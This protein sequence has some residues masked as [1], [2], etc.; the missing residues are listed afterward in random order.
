[1]P[2]MKLPLTNVN[3]SNKNRKRKLNS[4]SPSNNTPSQSRR[5][6]KCLGCGAAKRWD[7]L[8]D[9]YRKYVAF[10]PLGKPLPP[11]LDTMTP[12]Q[13]V[14][15]M[16]FRDQ[17]FA[18]DRMPQY[19]DHTEAGQDASEEDNTVTDEST[20]NSV[21]GMETNSAMIPPSL[22]NFSPAQPNMEDFWENK[23]FADCKIICKGGEEILTHRLILAAH[24]EYFYQLLVSTEP[25]EMELAVIMMPDHS[26]QDI[27]NMLQQLYNF[28]VN[29][30]A[31]LFDES[32]HEYRITDSTP[33][34][35]K[36]VEEKLEEDAASAKTFLHSLMNYASTL[37]NLR[38]NE[39]NEHFAI[40]NEDEHEPDNNNDDENDVVH[41]DP[42]LESEPDHITAVKDESNEMIDTL[43]MKTGSSLNPVYT[44]QVPGC[45]FSVKKSLLCIK[46]HILA[47][48]WSNIT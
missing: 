24:N 25:S 35:K 30:T 8:T 37:S 33:S 34:K 31:F 16:A 21:N 46:G 14:H 41:D 12:E 43:I 27:A 42:N 39:N 36:K 47:E 7:R 3:T 40:K 18:M 45:N 11:S 22:R 1:M 9:H 32:F 20:S 4:N 17:G 48:H 6:Y 29:D 38:K 5:F 19:K 2:Q 28:K 10:G 44:C 13:Y 23:N 15:T 26:S